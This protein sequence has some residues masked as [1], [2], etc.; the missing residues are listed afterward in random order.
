MSTTW[1]KWFVATKAN[2][3]VKQIGCVIVIAFALFFGRTALS[4]DGVVITDVFALRDDAFRGDILPDGSLVNGGTGDIGYF[5]AT[6]HRPDG[7]L[8]T[9]WGEGG[10]V[11]YFLG[12]DSITRG[13]A[14]ATAQPDGKVILAGYYH[15]NTN[16][17]PKGY[18]ALIRYDASGKIDK[19]FNKGKLVKTYFGDGK[20]DLAGANKV[21]VLP[22]NKILALGW[23]FDF[24]TPYKIAMARYLPNGTLDSSFG[25]G[26][27][28][29]SPRDLS[30]PLYPFLCSSGRQDP[31]RGRCQV[32][33]Q[34]GTLTLTTITT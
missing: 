9:S 4:Q 7:T 13:S 2:E 17:G 5:C 34:C 33:T 32:L 19:T 22:D 11:S 31:R 25:D 30:Q 26:G 24:A 14:G 23:F 12:D 16:K 27:M 1:R 28:V 20:N 10:F 18:F 8:D 3:T 21:I 6:K 29:I 15:V